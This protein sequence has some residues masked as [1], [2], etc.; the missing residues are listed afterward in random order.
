MIDKSIENAKPLFDKKNIK[1]ILSYNGDLLPKEAQELI[2]KF[3]EENDGGG[4]VLNNT[5]GD[6][7]HI[8]VQESLGTLQDGEFESEMSEA[9]R[10]AL[11][12]VLKAADELKI[13]KIFF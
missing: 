6:T 10:S 9:E 5:Y 4:F 3:I 11:I 12:A 1:T 2:H 7:K 8:W 13:D